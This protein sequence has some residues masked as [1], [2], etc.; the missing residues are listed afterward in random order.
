MVVVMHIAVT[1]VDGNLAENEID[2]IA[3]TCGAQPLLH[4]LFG[5]S[6][7]LRPV[8]VEWLG[9]AKPC[10]AVSIGRIV[11]DKDGHTTVKHLYVS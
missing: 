4:L 9:T 6:Q 3:Q 1:Y 5:G 7:G 2:V 11:G 10:K 8:I